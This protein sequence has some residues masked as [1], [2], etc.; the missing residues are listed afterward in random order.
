MFAKALYKYEQ[1]FG[2]KYAKSKTLRD[3][4][5]IL[6]TMVKNKAAVEV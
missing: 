1:I 2:L 5:P 6:N 4:L 3:K